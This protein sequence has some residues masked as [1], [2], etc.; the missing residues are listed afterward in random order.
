MV[1]GARPPDL[2]TVGVAGSC[3]VDRA[4]VVGGRLESRKALG[5]VVGNRVSTNFRQSAARLV[6]AVADKH[7]GIS[8]DLVEVLVVGSQPAVAGSAADEPVHGA[9]GT[10]A[11]YR[12]VG[13]VLEK[14]QS[15]FY[16]P[17]GRDRSVAEVGRER[18]RV[19]RGHL[20]PAE[21]RRLPLR[22]VDRDQWAVGHAS[23]AINAAH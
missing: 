19:V 14:T 16:E 15:A 3:L 2:I 22:G 8:K 9:E 1:T 11:R 23:L 20:Q 7:R 10:V 6:E 13:R 17:V 21:L 18:E 4:P 12:V 5:A